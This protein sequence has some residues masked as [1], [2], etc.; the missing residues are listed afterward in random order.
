MLVLSAPEIVLILVMLGI[1]LLPIWI[2]SKILKKAGFSGW[3]SL[4]G[5]IPGLNVIGLWMF[6]LIGWPIDGSKDNS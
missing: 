4:V 1:Y 6:A 2:F 3:L 5:L